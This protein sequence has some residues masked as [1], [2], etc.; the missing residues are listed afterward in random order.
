MATIN[1]DFDGTC[2]THEFPDIGKEIGAVPVLKTLIKNGHQLILFT[3]RCDFNDIENLNDNSVTYN[4]PKKYLQDAVDWFNKHNIPIYGIQCN[5]TQKD[6]TTSSKSY[7]EFMIDDSAIGTPMLYHPQ[8]SSRPFINWLQ[9]S[10]MLEDLYLIS[11]QD[12]VR[13]AE[14]LFTIYPYLYIRQWTHHCKNLTVL[15]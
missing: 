6:W 13:I 1:I 4:T 5:P 11:R 9:M 12:Q 8:F 2:T 3:M 14:E 7:A 15:K 10:R